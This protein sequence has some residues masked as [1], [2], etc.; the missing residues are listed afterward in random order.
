MSALP[1]QGRNY[2]QEL[3]IEKDSTQAQI[4]QAYRKLALQYHPKLSQED[5]NTSY[6]KF[7]TIS[8]AYE[9]LS[10]R[11]LRDFYDIH[12]EI[13]LKDGFFINDQFKGGYTFQGNPNEIFESFFGTDNPFTQL[14]DYQGKT[15]IKSLLGFQFDADKYLGVL[16][17]QDLHVEVPCT[18]NELYNGCKKQVSYKKTVL[19]GDGNTTREIDETKTIEI[20]KGYIDGHPIVFQGLGNQQAGNKP[21]DLI[22]NIKELKHKKF[23][24]NKDDLIY[25][26]K[27]K[28]VD[29]LCSTPVNIQTLDGRN[30]FISIDEIISPQTVK[31]V[32]GEGFPIYNPLEYEVEHY[33][34]ELQKGDLQIK[35]DIIFPQYIEEEKKQEVQEILEKLY[36]EEDME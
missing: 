26:H 27:I 33:N 25:V 29:A 4:A 12:G 17:P 13:K 34:Q 28:L 10:D 32:E 16:P 21:S 15:P 24:R 36:T 30:L 31:I 22:F 11:K 20:K 23:Q 7:C 35:F 18:L 19:N 9:V 5:Y 8:E 6:K 1:Q 3:Q 14:Y 2:Y